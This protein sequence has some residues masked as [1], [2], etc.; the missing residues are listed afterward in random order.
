MKTNRTTPTLASVYSHRAA[1][2][3]RVNA[4]FLAL[5]TRTTFILVDVPREMVGVP[6]A[7]WCTLAV[8]AWRA[9][10]S[11]RVHLFAQRVPDC[12]PP[13]Y[14]IDPGEAVC[15]NIHMLL[16]DSRHGPVYCETLE[17]T[18]SGPRLVA[19]DPLGRRRPNW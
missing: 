6:V 15:R 8:C 9:P 7:G 10:G 17:I 1:I 19:A 18:P 5:P 16:T 4:A 13:V 2:R 11:A 14:R 3:W 12:F